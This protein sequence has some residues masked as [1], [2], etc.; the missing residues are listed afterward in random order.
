MSKFFLLLSTCCFLFSASAVYSDKNYNNKSLQGIGVIETQL[1][2]ENRSIHTSD[3]LKIVDIDTI[4]VSPNGKYIAFPVRRVN[5][6]NDNYVTEWFSMSVENNST[7]VNIGDA[8]EIQMPKIRGRPNGYILH[9]KATWL[10][11]NRRISYIKLEQGSPQVWLSDI[12]SA[13]QLRLTSS[14]YEIEDFLW[15]EDESKIFLR[16]PPHTKKESRLRLDHDRKKG[17]LYD[18]RIE[19]NRSLEPTYTK[20][21]EYTFTVGIRANPNTSFNRVFVLETGLERFLTTAEQAEVTRILSKEN[22]SELSKQ[23]D[24]SK[25]T[26][27]LIEFGILPGLK[28]KLTGQSNG[29]LAWA[30]RVDKTIKSREQRLRLNIAPAG[31]VTRVQTCISPLCSGRISAIWSS[32]ASGKLYF[33]KQTGIGASTTQ[34]LEWDFQADTVK[35]IVATDDLLSEC[36]TM[37][38]EHLVCLRSN[39]VTPVEIVSIDLISGDLRPVYSPNESIKSRRAS[40]VERVELTNKFGHK[41]FGYVV[42][43]PNYNN[44]TTYPLI[45]TQYRARGFLRGA[46]GD[47]YPIYP[48]ADKGFVVLALEA[49]DVSPPVGTATEGELE[50][51]ARENLD[52]FEYRSNVAS[53]DAA[54]SLLTNRGLVDSDRIGISGLSFGAAITQFAL[55]NSEYHFAAAIVSG[56][57][58]DP[59]GYFVG[60]DLG[61]DVLNALGLPFPDESSMEKWK[62]VSLSLNADKVT[63]PLLMNISDTEFLFATQTIESFRHHSVPLEAYIFSNS[64][65]LKTSPCHREAIYE[66]NIDWFRF[67]LQRYEH[68]EPQ[69]KQQYKRWRKMR[70]KQVKL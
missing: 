13:Q 51:L 19:T 20:D 9:K 25:A 31:D 40:E 30:D 64:L 23:V 57:S 4:S 32:T 42:L 16:V 44:N 68:P 48:L 17:F 12:A 45:I 6:K 28:P 26:Y 69:K 34:I 47:E 58:F 66:R 1:L 11:D 61:R 59:I 35:R 37:A 21:I 27:Q 14:E 5:L 38:G 18:R 65:H 49:T 33:Q 10:S 63:T 3:L 24:L 41:T 36:Q 7:L 15:S 43:P 22:A 53:I 8:G 29:Y 2:K 46:T 67:W 60:P 54:I 55:F 62:E 50:T 52:W 39:A 70:A 56:S